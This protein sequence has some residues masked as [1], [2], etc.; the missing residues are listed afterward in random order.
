MRLTLQAG[1]WHPTGRVVHTAQGN[2][3]Q[4]VATEQRAWP[5]AMDA[6]WQQTSDRILSWT[7]TLSC[8]RLSSWSVQS[9]KPKR[10]ARCPRIRFRLQRLRR[11]HQGQSRYAYQEKIFLQENTI[12]FSLTVASW[13]EVNEVCL[14]HAHKTIVSLAG[15]ARSRRCPPWFDCDVRLCPKASQKQRFSNTGMGSL[16][17]HRN[18][19][20]ADRSIHRTSPNTDGRRA[21]ITFQLPQWSCFQMA[22]LF[23]LS[24]HSMY[25]LP[26]GV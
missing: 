18:S 12:S 20:A 1:G 19:C 14:L 3:G 23:T 7:R 25:G 22:D 4:I 2:L 24:F 26:F 11:F 9:S 15:F 13:A 10:Q 8:L 5:A 17:G 21:G 16:V 6:R